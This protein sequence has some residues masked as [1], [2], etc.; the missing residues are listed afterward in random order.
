MLPTRQQAFSLIEL[1]TTLVVLGILLSIALPSL[2]THIQHSR[3]TTQVN[4]ML[5]ALYY[6]RA[7]AITSR[8]MVSLCAGDSSCG[9]STRWHQQILIFSDTNRDG[10]FDEGDSLL[11]VASLAENYSWNWSNFRNQKHMSFK[12]NGATHALNGTFT[13]C[14]NTQAIKRVVINLSG[15][16]KLEPPTDS[17]HCTQ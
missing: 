13:L 6:A 3:Q 10:H 9:D 2:S 12:A 4:L 14:Q 15:R 5:G 16:A 8:T 11:H 1:L 17:L 7:K